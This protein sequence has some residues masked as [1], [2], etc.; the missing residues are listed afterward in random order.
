VRDVPALLR[1]A[2]MFVLS[3]ISE[4]VPLAVLE[5][6]ASGLA[7]AATRVG[8]V[9][10]I[11]SD[12]VTGLLTPPRDPAALAAALMRL[13]GDDTLTSAMGARGRRRVEEAF[14]VRRMVAAYEQL[15]VE[16]A[17]ARH[18]ASAKPQ[19]ANKNARLEKVQGCA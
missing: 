6:M 9:P 7:V 5:A 19:A 16:S 1:Q 12:G 3:S 18:Y 2:R 8:G 10:D 4:G 11:V 14:D 15:Y 17:S 13:H